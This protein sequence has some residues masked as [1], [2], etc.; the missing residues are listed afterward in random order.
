[1]R[2]RPGKPPRHPDM[3]KAEPNLTAV[4]RLVRTELPTDTVDTIDVEHALAVLRSEN[5]RL[6]E[7]VA[8]DAKTAAQSEEDHKRDIACRQNENLKLQEQLL[9]AQERVYELQGKLLSLREI[10]NS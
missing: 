1:M 2:E 8:A 6:R 4:N 3:T 5:A 7:R 9:A 10:V